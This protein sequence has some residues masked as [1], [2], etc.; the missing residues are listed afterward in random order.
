MR[1][2]K[3][4]PILGLIALTLVLLVAGAAFAG[5]EGEGG[6]EPGQMKPCP[7]QER[8]ARHKE[9]QEKHVAMAARLDELVA[10][11]NEAEGQAKA[12]AVAAVVNELVAQHKMMH[13]RMMD[14]SPMMHNGMACGHGHGMMQ[15][16]HGSQCDCPMMQKME[17]KM[18]MQEG[19]A[20]EEH[21]E[22]HPEGG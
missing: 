22:H 1:A 4:F 18:E 8:M 9:M 20:G 3:R 6:M 7:C 16:M 2:H 15:G 5:E 17:P 21:S 10:A 13:G 14:H 12:D 19:G 11:M